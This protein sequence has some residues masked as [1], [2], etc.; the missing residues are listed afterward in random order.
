MCPKIV[1]K[2]KKREEILHA[3]MKVFAEKGVK[4]ARMA[5]IAQRAGIGKGTIYEYFRSREEIFM[6]GF[7]LLLR[8][9][10]DGLQSVLEVP[11]DPETK[12]KSVMKI[13]FSSLAQLSAEMTGILI[14]FWHEGIHSEAAKGGGIIDLKQVY[15]DIRNAVRQVVAD[16]IMAGQ[17][18]EVDPTMVASVIMAIVDGLL[19]QWILDKKAFDL[20]SVVEGSMGI[21]L[22]GI[23]L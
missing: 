15:D 17:F 8:D 14:D 20:D 12:L 19:L 21:V 4:R 5:D 9:M 6:E 10:K 11:A 3:A 7:N 22:K 16:G 23:K 18:R 1:D 13:F 2:Q